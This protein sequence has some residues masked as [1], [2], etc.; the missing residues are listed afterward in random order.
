MPMQ[1]LAGTLPLTQLLSQPI[2]PRTSIVRSARSRNRAAAW[3]YDLAQWRRYQLAQ[4]PTRGEA[5]D[6]EYARLV[7]Q[8]P[9]FLQYREGSSFTEAPACKITRDDRAKM[10]HAFDLVRTGL[11]K[12]GRRSR[13]QA[14]SRA[15]KEVLSAVLAFGIK[16]GRAYPSLAT[17]AAMCCCSVRTVQRALD[18]LR[19]FGFLTWIKRLTRVRTPLG[20]TACRQTSNGYR[21]TA[22]LSGL[23]AMA[24]N[25]FSQGAMATTANHQFEMASQERSRSDDGASFLDRILS[26]HAQRSP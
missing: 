18:W 5:I 15:Y 2:Q 13:A 3:S 6:A 22:R 16:Y 23:S 25:V 4:H 14:V 11:W 24:L 10:V 26:R 19:L 21:L 8:G 1:P 17:L 9:S 12:H 7:E 20:S